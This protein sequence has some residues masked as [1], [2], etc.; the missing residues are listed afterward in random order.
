[1]LALRRP[2]FS[3]GH[4]QGLLTK[5]WGRVQQRLYEEENM[6]GTKFS[7][8]KWTKAV[9]SMI[10]TFNHTMLKNRCELVQ[11]MD[12]ETLN[13]RKRAQLKKKWKS[14]CK[15]P[16][17]LRAGDP[18][19]LQKEEKFFETVNKIALDLWEQRLFVALEQAH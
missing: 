11:I 13:R 5:E 18:H 16:W 12:E 3:I 10:L 14:L 9:L 8:D 19:L 17:R 4:I 1:M 2:I 7:G 6:D 15:Q